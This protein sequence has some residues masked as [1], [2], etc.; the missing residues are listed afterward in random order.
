LVFIDK[1]WISIDPVPA[2]LILFRNLFN[3]FEK[4]SP[5]LK[6]KNKTDFIVDM[7]R[8]VYPQY[9]LNR[10]LNNLRFESEIRSLVTGKEIKLT[11][12]S[13]V[14][15]SIFEQITQY[16][17]MLQKNQLLEKVISDYSH[18]IQQINLHTHGLE[19]FLLIREKEISDLTGQIQKNNQEMISLEKLVTTQKSQIELLKKNI[20]DAN[21]HA[22]GLSQLVSHREVQIENFKEQVRQI[23]L[24]AEGLEQI[25]RENQWN[26][27]LRKRL[28]FLGKIIDPCLG[29][30]TL[31]KKAFHILLHEG[32]L[33]LIRQY[34]ERSQ[35]KKFE[36]DHNIRPNEKKEIVLYAEN[37]IHDLVFPDNSKNPDVSIIIP[38]YNQ[39]QY[40]LNCLY[41]ISSKTQGSYEI[42]V[43]DD[44]SSDSTII[45]LKNIK[46]ITIIKNEQNL[47]FVRC[48]NTGAAASR[49]KYLLFL[50]NDTIVTEN[51]L[52]PLL[53][54]IKSETVG[55]VGSKLI[56][57]D[58]KLQ[59]AGAIVWNDA[60]G[61]NYGRGDDPEKPEYNF[62]RPVDYCSGAALL[63]KKEIFERIGGFDERYIPAYYEDA[64]LCFSIRKSGYK[65]MYQPKSVV[66]HF[67]GISNGLEINAG[68]KRNQVIN[69]E[70]FFLKW[71]N[72]L[73]EKHLNPNRLNLISARSRTSGKTILVIDQYVPFFDRDA[74]SQR[75]SNILKILADLGHKVTFIGDNF[76]HFDPYD[77]IMQ[78]AGVEVIYSPFI[79]SIEQYLIQFGQYYDI[80]ILSRPHIVE[81]YIAH[82]RKYCLR[83]K[84]V[85]DTVDLQ[86][87]RESRR[88]EVLQDPKLMKNVDE[89][90]KWELNLAKA[91]DATLVVCSNE[92]QIL[93]KEDPSLNVSVISLIHDVITPE[94]NFSERKNI[95][96]LGAFLHNPNAD[97][98]LWF[99]KEIFPKI[100]LHI[101][102]V[103]FFVV[104][105]RP[106]DE[107]SSL[108]SDNIIVTGYVEDVSA[109]F[110]TCRVF[111][112]PLRYGAGV[113]GKINHSM[114]H[115]LP[116]VTTSIG[117][118]GL[119]V[120]DNENVLIADDPDTFSQKVIQLYSDEILW[121]KLSKNS[122][123][124]IRQNFSFEHSKKIIQE[125]IDSFD[126]K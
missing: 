93:I 37:E 59:E 95:M 47:G 11:M 69:K 43:V 55:A 70:K 122:I 19:Q 106:T 88:A 2:D 9:S 63:V 10:L 16:N 101:P 45:T 25:L 5:F 103:R 121:N 73:Q 76:N 4:F 13:P 46:N 83:A 34:K 112:A 20:S 3:I 98:V 60:S 94:K 92:Q 116:V 107:I 124:H 74:G 109:Y 6:I 1:K 72:I 64:D 22:Y 117:A 86:F 84:V 79:A 87:I 52:P 126:K 71:K 104:G 119:E 113:K 23:T 68:I 35:I 82:V 21:I 118:E 123:E 66:I 125:F 77:S 102:D 99:I 114:S 108:S 38:V 58:G 78:N 27:K 54:V 97:G 85:Y 39:L 89:L 8:S 81:K 15:Y 65:V 28:G 48:C 24:H 36:R 91:S 75:M 14:Q 41:S 100:I 105:D 96:F 17:E 50:N 32:L 56:Y 40:T 115:G 31:G 12:E 67:E 18:Q 61:W 120:T 57:P 26:I 80:V 51:W 33:D 53:D 42:I 90:K 30:F 7:I 49:G 29:I 110:N 111:V 62:L 44:A